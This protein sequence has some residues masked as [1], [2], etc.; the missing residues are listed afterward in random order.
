MPMLI[1]P[2]S[3]FSSIA[4]L[5]EFKFIQFLRSGGGLLWVGALLMC[6]WNSPFLFPLLCKCF[7][8][9]LIVWRDPYAD[10]SDVS[11]GC[12]LGLF[13]LLFRKFMVSSNVLFGCVLLSVLC[14]QRRRTRT[15]LLSRSFQGNDDIFIILEPHPGTDLFNN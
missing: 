5:P 8:S 7:F 15:C 2:L 12:P 4:S 11:I 1:S 14:L 10:V 9:P 13:V 3:I 6:C